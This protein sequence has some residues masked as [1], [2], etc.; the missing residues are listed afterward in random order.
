MA[1]GEEAVGV[2]LGSPVRQDGTGERKFTDYYSKWDKVAK[3]AVEEVEK[4]DAVQVASST[5]ALGLDSDDPKSEAHKKD[6]EKR[7]GLKEAKKNWDGMEAKRSEAKMVIE[8]ESD[9]PHRSLE[10]EGEL[11][12]RRVLVLKDNTGCSY[13][14]GPDLDRHGIIK[15][16]VEKCKRCRIVLHCKLVTS[17]IEICHCEGCTVEVRHPTHTF[18]IDLCESTHV[19]FAQNVLHPGHKIYSAGNRGLQI[20]FD[21]RGEL[22]APET[23][24][25][26][27]NCK[28]QLLDNFELSTLPTAAQAAEQ[29]FVTQ[30]TNLALT[31]TKMDIDLQ[32]ECVTRDVGMQPTTGREIQDRK[33]EI[34]RSLAARGIDDASIERAQNRLDAPAADSEAERLK[35]EG[36]KAFK[37]RHYVQASIYYVQALQAIEFEQP[38]QAEKV[39]ELRSIRLACY[40]NRSACQLKLGDH[41]TA[42]QDADCGLAIDPDH[43]KCNF[44]RGLALHAMGR[45]TE[46]CPSLGKA[47]RLEPKNKQIKEALMFAERG[48]QKQME[49]ANRTR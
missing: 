32:T 26:G 14:L 39:A 43:V 33:D 40:S 13:E 27:K 4:D 28:Q 2:K 41:A 25:E 45:S 44:R 23:S 3:D 22:A 21:D 10:F 49:A 20:T 6:M 36:N 8:K 19:W 9:Q 46:A 15:L 18:Q 30:L 31:D 5:A 37:E 42:L 48:A 12:G 35:G 7:A 17:L 29:Q 16:Y 24:R 1:S 47:L 38:R 34:Q 11:N